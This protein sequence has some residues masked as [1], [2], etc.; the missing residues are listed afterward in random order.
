[1]KTHIKLILALLSMAIL[2]SALNAIPPG[3][4]SQHL[5]VSGFEEIIVP[6]MPAAEPGWMLLTSKYTL[7]VNPLE[8]VVIE[9]F[10]EWTYTEDAAP[11]GSFFQYGAGPILDAPGG[12]VIGSVSFMNNGAYL[13]PPPMLEWYA[14]GTAVGTIWDGPYAG[15]IL[16]CNADLEAQVNLLT[17]ELIRY[18]SL[19]DGFLIATDNVAD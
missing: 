11:D 9:L 6:P 1:M 7:A 2:G 15:M 12:N 3:T 17:G 16:T 10:I 18:D 14:D 4:G 19:L 13:N 5:R 8:G